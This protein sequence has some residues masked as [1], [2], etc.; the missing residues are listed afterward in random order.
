MA[1]NAIPETMI[2]PMMILGSIECMSIPALLLQFD[3][4]RGAHHHSVCAG[5]VHRYKAAAQ[6]LFPAR[7]AFSDVS[8]T[9]LR[10]WDHRC[11]CTLL[12]NSLAQTGILSGYEESTTNFAADSRSRVR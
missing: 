4:R 2:A 12:A 3:L 5:F 8:T 1:I 11:I 9:A 7:C 6:R 10:P